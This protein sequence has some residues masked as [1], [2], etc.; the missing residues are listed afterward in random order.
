MGLLKHDNLHDKAM[1][2]TVRP[3]LVDV[4]QPHSRDALMVVDAT[5]P[6]ASRTFIAP[7]GAHTAEIVIFE[8]EL[9]AEQRPADDPGAQDV[10]IGSRFLSGNKVPHSIQVPADGGQLILNSV[11]GSALGGTARIS[12]N[13]LG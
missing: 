9:V 13:W 11:D 3:L 8:G 1:D 7:A 12:I 2:R 6:L 5:D 4:C 10:G